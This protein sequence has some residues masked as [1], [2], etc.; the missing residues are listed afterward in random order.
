[1]N[2]LFTES[3]PNIGGQEL[4]AVA[5]M[6]ALKKMGHSVLLVCRENSKI[7]LEASMSGI[8]ITFA[9]FRN[10]LH[11]PTARKI[12]RIVRVFQ[13]HAIVCHSGH[14]SNIV[15]L[16]RLFTRRHSFQII[17]QKTYLTQK[18]KVFSLNH[19][20]DEVI[21][22]GTSMKAHLI[23]EGCRTRVTVVPPGFDFQQLYA[24]SQTSLPP[25]VLSWL[26]AG[27]YVPVIAQIG[28]LRPE[29]GHEFMLNLLFRLKMNGRQFR[30]LIVGSGS[31]EQRKHLQYQID[32]MGM[33]ENTFIADNIFPATPVYRVASLVVLPSENESFGMVLAEASVFS[34][35]VL[36]SQ[37]GGIPDVIQNNQTGTLLPVGNE[38]AWLCTLNDF[39]NAPERF[40][41][42]ARLAKQDMKERFD[43]NKTVLKILDLTKRR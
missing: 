42:M 3:S 7:A 17:R 29:K 13:P 14:D 32:N 23:Q 24:D 18:T 27:K 33:H 37:T 19:F 38:H 34:V 22:P 26:T 43:I 12:L 6:K 9:S 40:Y 5:Q 31:S 2:I 4:Q 8:D 39:F 35:P 1:M 21:V 11:I 16:V 25:K 41:Q 36:A 20:C 30:W 15:G 10:S 28:M